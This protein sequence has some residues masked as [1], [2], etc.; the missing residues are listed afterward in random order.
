MGFWDLIFLHPLIQSQVAR[1]WIAVI[2]IIA[3]ALQLM[4]G[5][6]TKAGIDT[7]LFGTELRIIHIIGFFTLLAGLWVY[8][9]V[10]GL[11]L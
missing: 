6:I 5:F 3:S 11:G 1:K 2:V 4:F 9:R 10:G 7:A 8:K